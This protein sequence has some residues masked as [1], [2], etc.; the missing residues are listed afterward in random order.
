MTKQT[1]L[2]FNMLFISPYF[3][4]KLDCSQ[5]NG[6]ADGQLAPFL[7]FYECS[8]SCQLN[9]ERIYPFPCPC[10]VTSVSRDYAASQRQKQNKSQRYVIKG[11]IIISGHLF[12]CSTDTFSYTLSTQ[13]TALYSY[14]W[15][16]AL[17]SLHSMPFLHH[18]INYVSVFRLRG[19][20]QMH[21]HDTMQDG[22]Q[23]S[24]ERMTFDQCDEPVSGTTAPLVS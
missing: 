21:A 12:I 1:L 2:I 9:W 19:D 23:W 24:N 6:W 7:L 20:E 10:T 22:V 17:L 8:R 11:Y 5:Q 18:Y 14:L 16:E 15:I 4:D 3:C 13:G